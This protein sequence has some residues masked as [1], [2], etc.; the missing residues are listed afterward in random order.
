MLLEGLIRDDLG[1]NQYPAFAKK[2]FTNLR[3][4]EKELLFP[5]PSLGLNL[6][7]LFVQPSL[8]ERMRE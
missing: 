2:P 6:Q 3:R 5:L 1:E 8:Y 4:K 7:S